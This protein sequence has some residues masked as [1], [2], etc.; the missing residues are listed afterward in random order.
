MFLSKSLN[1]VKHNYEIH[2]KEMLAIICALEEWQHFLEGAWQLVKV[3]MD[4]KNLEYFRTTKKLN[5]RQ[6]QW[7]IFLSRF[8]YSLHH[9]PGRSMDKLDALLRRPDHGNGSKDNKDVVLLKLQLFVVR[10]LEVMMVEGEEKDIMKEIRR[11]NSLGEQE[12]AVVVAAKVLKEL[13]G[14]GLRGDEWRE[15]QGVLYYCDCIYV[16]KNAD[17]RRRIVTQYH[18]SRI[19]RHPGRWKTLELVSHSY[20]WPQMLRYIGLYCSTCNLCLQMKANCSQPIRHLHPL[21]IPPE[22]WHT[23]SVVHG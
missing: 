6:A 18:D 20:W 10:V 9:C 5:Q 21:A 23:V 14:K 3:W 19:A 17:L 15:D 7:S 11:R 16:P 8:D 4:H 12:E 1:V 22:R 13:K 2:D